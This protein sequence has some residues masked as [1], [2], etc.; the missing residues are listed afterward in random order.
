MGAASAGGGRTFEFEYVVQVDPIAEGA[1]DVRVFI[2]LPMDDARQ[3]VLEEEIVTSVPGRIETEPVHGNRFYHLA[4]PADGRTLDVRIRVRVEREITRPGRRAGTSGS[5]LA[6][7]LG[8]NA[9]VVVDHP[10]L[11]PML[12]EI[13]HR[14][15]PGASEKKARAIYDWVVDHME[16]KKVG[17]GWGNGDTFWACS[18]RYGNC[19]DFHALVI[20]LARTEGIPARFEIGFPVPEDR[21]QGEIDGYHCWVELHLEETGWL[22]IDAAEASKH[23]DKRELF[24][25]THP[26]DRIHFT[27][28]RDLKLGP[29]HRGPPLN[30]FIYPH[31]EI[32]GQPHD[33]PIKTRFRYRDLPPLPAGL[34]ESKHQ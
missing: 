31:V 21:S 17:S 4:Y 23:P 34:G 24:Y 1:G 22:P 10:I 33:V 13:R 32:D 16:Y 14:A 7:Y 5:E 29:D 6:R 12:E 28:G 8:E 25:G 26:A 2:P 3:H 27:T 15:G 19:T 30:F 11:H 20:S 18:E 9:R